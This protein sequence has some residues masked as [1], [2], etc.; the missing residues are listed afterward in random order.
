[1]YEDLVKR[2]REIHP[3]EF[4]D[5]WDLAFACQQTMHE[6]ADA[7]EELSMTADSYKRSME[8]WGDE[9]Y[10]AYKKYAKSIFDSPKEE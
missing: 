10:R 8:A 6:A 2:L 5:A 3:E 4:G 9:A 1:M 7:I